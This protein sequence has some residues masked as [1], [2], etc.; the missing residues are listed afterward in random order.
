S[1]SVDQQG[2]MVENVEE[3]VKYQARRT[4]T[5]ANWVKAGKN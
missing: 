3:A 2:K 4:V 1:V 5:V